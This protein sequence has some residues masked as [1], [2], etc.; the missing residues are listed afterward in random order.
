MNKLNNEKTTIDYIS[1]LW[2]EFITDIAFETTNEKPDTLKRCEIIGSIQEEIKSGN[3]FAKLCDAVFEYDETKRA[4]N[5]RHSSYDVTT[6]GLDKS[7]KRNFQVL[8]F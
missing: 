8:A 2:N 5:F 4:F 1:G 6:F 7:G 3:R